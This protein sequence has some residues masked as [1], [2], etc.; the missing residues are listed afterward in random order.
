MTRGGWLAGAVVVAA[1]AVVGFGMLYFGGGNGSPEA[2]VTVRTAEVRS[3]GDARP[4]FDGT[5]A[6]G[7]R[8]AVTATR[9]GAV[10]A[11]EVAVGDE[12]AAGDVLVRF[13]Q[14]GEQSALMTAEAEIDQARA[15]LG[16]ARDRNES[17]DLGETAAR[18]D[19]RRLA[20]LERQLT[21]AEDR[22]AGAEA[23][24][25]ERLVRAPID[26][27]VREVSTEVGT[28]VVAG[29]PLLGLVNDELRLARFEVPRALAVA[30]EPG[31]SVMVDSDGDAHSAEVLEVR[32]PEDGLAPTVTVEVAFDEPDLADGTAV[33]LP[34]PDDGRDWLAVQS[35]ALIAD[36]EGG[37]LYR[38]ADG[39]AW[40]V[41]V[42]TLP[43]GAPATD[44]AWVR[45][46]LEP[47]ERVA[48]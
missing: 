44:Q 47:G 36:D 39:T 28:L 4:A 32:R 30:F 11:I 14:T 41:R 48:V 3:G 5:V 31:L 26:G 10:S 27:V 33:E 16:R 29:T 22:L 8:L 19:E 21:A 23:D 37:W 24:V 12:V 17:A 20:E 6:A 1:L 35:D 25:E 43:T 15:E 13:E 34:L 46:P 38:I 9:E 45:G 18:V 2:A 40:M 7:G 42:E